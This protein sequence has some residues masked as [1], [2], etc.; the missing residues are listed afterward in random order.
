LQ[1][2]SFLKFAGAA[3]LAV[4]GAALMS[5]P[6]LAAV[7]QSA[8]AR[9]KA[10]GAGS[11]ALRTDA[12]VTNGSL[13]RPN[14]GVTVLG[15]VRRLHLVH[16]FSGEEFNEVYWRNGQYNDQALQQ[17]NFL[18]RDR[19]GGD[20]QSQMDPALFDLLYDL[21]YR[22][23]Y[24]GPLHVISGYRSANRSPVRK[25]AGGK[26]KTKRFGVTASSSNSLHGQGLAADIRIPDWDLR[27]V[28][29]VAIAME[30]GGVGMYAHNHHLHLDTG[31]AR[32]WG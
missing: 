8:A 29:K 15:N 3:G 7:K 26:T 30:R 32:S 1:R 23:G 2:R 4:A 13:L 10:S 19:N 9:H 14:Q 21:K 18:M 25:T 31:P 17:L 11:G 28:G 24:N 5:E 16:P 20:V 27:A 12:A 6:A 22:I